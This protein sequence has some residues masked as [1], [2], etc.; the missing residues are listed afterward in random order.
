LLGLGVCALLL[1]PR[2]A[3]AGDLSLPPGT[4]AILE[5][6]YSGERIWRFR[7]RRRWNA[8]SRSIRWDICWK[9]EAGGG[10]S[11][12]FG[13]LQIRDELPRHRGKATGDQVYLD[14]VAKA[15]ALADAALA[16]HESAEMHLYAGMA[17]GLASRM[18]GL[19]ARIGQL[20]APGFGRVNISCG[21]WRLILR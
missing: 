21:R 3:D 12:A 8:S 7:R 14:V 2:R 1:G 20:R 15:E 19:R 13:G 6:I 16:K 10:R 11:G 9:A 5:H 17:G 18:L 4:D